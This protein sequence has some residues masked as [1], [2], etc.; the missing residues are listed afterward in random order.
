MKSPPEN[1]IIL[2]DCAEGLKRL[3]SE[4][5]HLTVTSPPYGSIRT[6]GGSW[7]FDFHAVADELW[8]VTVPG[9]VVVWVVQEQIVKGSESGES[10]HQRLYFAN[11][12]FRLHHTMV[13]E[14]IGGRNY[15]CN[16]YGFPL[17]YMMVLSKGKPRHTCLIRDRKN[18]HLSPHAWATRNPD[19]SYRRKKWQSKPYGV[20]GA[21]WRYVPGWMNTTKDRFAFDHPALM[22]EQMAEDHI[23][24]WSRI[25]DI[26]LDPFSGAGTTAKMAL[27]NG[28]R[29]IGFEL[30]PKY[31][32]LARRRIQEAE[33]KLAAKRSVA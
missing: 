18:M 7:Q 1:Q 14:R 24:S 3:P 33:Q 8:R 15:N 12:G 23:K 19:G 16:R 5:I 21:V 10:S 6:Y 4:S 26:V 28:R 27:L 29:F 17:E 32:R 30:N 31:V 2:A 22:H 20:R 25:G 13:A 9:G 11:I